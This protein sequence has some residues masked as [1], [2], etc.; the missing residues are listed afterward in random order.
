MQIALTPENFN[1]QLNSSTNNDSINY[2]S[3]DGFLENEIAPSD[4]Q[5]EG[6]IGKNEIFISHR[7][8]WFIFSVFLILQITM[9]LDHGTVPA[10]TDEIRQ[11]L[12]IDDNVLG[13][14]ASLVFVGNLIGKIYFI[15]FLNSFLRFNYI[16]K[17]NKQIS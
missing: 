10:A 13:L 12:K 16:L 11:D 4:L 7:M 8:R 6:E 9:N 1:E 14:F 15:Y 2:T 5:I 3:N 17:Y